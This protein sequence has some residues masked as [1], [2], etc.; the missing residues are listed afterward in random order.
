MEEPIGPDAPA[1]VAVAVVAC[2]ALALRVGRGDARHNR[3]LLGEVGVRAGL[4]AG[5]LGRPHEAAAG[6]VERQEYLGAGGG[7]GVRQAGPAVSLAG[8]PVDRLQQR[9]CDCK[10][11]TGRI[12]GFYGS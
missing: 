5:L 1:A 2:P 11:T 10:L 4:A 7:A 9:R 8:G 3:A 6:G 12:D